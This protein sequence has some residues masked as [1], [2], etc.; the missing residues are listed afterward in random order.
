MKLV[1]RDRRV[2]FA[3]EDK[4]RI[5]VFLRAATRSLAGPTRDEHDGSMELG[6]AL[7]IGSDG[8]RKELGVGIA[9]LVATSGC[10]APDVRR[11]RLSRHLDPPRLRKRR[12]RVLKLDRP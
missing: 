8:R 4:K 7:I 1:E 3:G 5:G 12:S 2:F 9:V 10:A 11:Y 6:A